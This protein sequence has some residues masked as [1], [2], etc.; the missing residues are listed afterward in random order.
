MNYK[1]R[2]TRRPKKTSKRLNKKTDR[3]KRNFVSRNKK[4]Q[5]YKNDE[6]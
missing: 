1:N 5:Q 2:S 3:P 6:T 4:W